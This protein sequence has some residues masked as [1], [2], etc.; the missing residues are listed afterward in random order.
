[1]ATTVLINCGFVSRLAAKEEG[2]LEN[3][4]K[5]ADSVFGRAKDE[6]HLLPEETENR[7]KW[8]MTLRSAQWNVNIIL[9]R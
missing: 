2:S 4:K 9:L 8:E 7:R 1:M 5:C 3:K 6:K